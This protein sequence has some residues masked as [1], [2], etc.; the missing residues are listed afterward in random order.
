MATTGA[1]M[2]LTVLLAWAQQALRTH[3]QQRQQATVLPGVGAGEW[4]Q[5]SLLALLLWCAA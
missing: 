5:R 2:A 1:Q 4:I 3:Q